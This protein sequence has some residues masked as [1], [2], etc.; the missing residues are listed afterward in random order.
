M[1]RYCLSTVMVV[2]KYR[3]MRANCT[4][5]SSTA[6]AP[7]SNLISWPASRCNSTP[8]TR[9]LA[10]MSETR[11]ASAI[12]AI[13]GVSERAIATAD[14]PPLKGNGLS[15]MFR[16]NLQPIVVRYAHGGPI[17]TEAPS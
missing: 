12:P 17:Q 11:N 2:W 7:A 10:G 6:K 9:S 13:Q 1:Y 15:V 8:M 3:T 14:V 4:N 16:E 5:H